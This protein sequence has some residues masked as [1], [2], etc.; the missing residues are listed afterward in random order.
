[1]K[2]QWETILQMPLIKTNESP[3]RLAIFKSV[4]AYSGSIPL[5]KPFCPTRWCCKMSSLKTSLQNYQE[6]LSFLEN[7]GLEKSNAV[8]KAKVLSEFLRS[9]NFIFVTIIFIEIWKPMEVLNAFLQSFFLQLQLW[10]TF[11]V[12]KKCWRCLDKTPV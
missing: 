4:Q 6:L 12:P 8:A 5:L 3:K 10:K 7:T 2:Q 9:F 11:V 1:M